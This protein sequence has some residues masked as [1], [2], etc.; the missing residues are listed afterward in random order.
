M[1]A[2][3]LS[4]SYPAGNYSSLFKDIAYDSPFVGPMTEDQYSIYQ[5]TGQT[6]GS[7]NTGSVA[8]SY[9]TS[10]YNSIMSDTRSAI[11]NPNY[12]YTYTPRSGADRGTSAQEFLEGMGADRDSIFENGFEEYKLDVPSYSMFMGGEEG[13]S[14]LDRATNLMEAVRLANKAQADDRHT[15]VS[16]LMDLVNDK[17]IQGRQNI[18][19]DNYNTETEPLQT[20]ELFKD[21]NNNAPF[22]GPMTNDQYQTYLLTGQTPG[23]AG[24]IFP[25]SSNIGPVASF[26]DYN[27]MLNPADPEIESLKFKKIRNVND[28]ALQS[29]DEML[30]NYQDFLGGTNKFTMEHYN[31][32]L[33]TGKQDEG[34]VENF[35]KDF[36][37]LGGKA[38]RKVQNKFPDLFTYEASD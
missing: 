7:T 8:P 12:Q 35:L 2:Q 36:I 5:Q 32:A 1:Y 23:S 4:T 18:F 13:Q 17:T 34:D 28:E 31:R 6:P 29:E 25:N 30:A 3:V 24:N 11:S 14:S 19:S 9:P 33:N 37:S 27:A 10:S 38:G 26:E 22:V 20:S 21:I 15:M 16:D